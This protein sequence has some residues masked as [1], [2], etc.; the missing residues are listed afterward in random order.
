MIECSR[1]FALMLLQ[2]RSARD[3]FV[4]D[5]MNPAV[6]LIQLFKHNM[7]EDFLIKAYT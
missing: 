3:E 7:V 5:I 1:Q 6:C 4:L 2:L